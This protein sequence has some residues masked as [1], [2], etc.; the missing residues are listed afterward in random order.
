MVQAGL[1]DMQAGGGAAD[2]IVI[3]R[4]FNAAQSFSTEVNQAL[5]SL[6]SVPNISAVTAQASTLTSDLG[7][8][9]PNN[10]QTLS[11]AIAI[12]NAIVALSAAVGGSSTGPLTPV[13]NPAPP[14]F[15]PNGP[16]TPNNGT[17]GGGG[18]NPVAVP[19]GPSG[20]GS[21]PSGSSAGGT[22]STGSTGDTGATGSTGVPSP[23]LAPVGSV[24]AGT[25][26]GTGVIAWA[27][28]YLFL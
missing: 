19:S 3:S 11:D 8:G 23:D 6:S 1:S 2:A 18:L 22:G 16:T 9:N 24:V 10:Q 7:S 27:L 21:G 15:N 20:S 25:V 14:P 13:N 12:M 4:A 5:S 26:V 17:Q 28:W